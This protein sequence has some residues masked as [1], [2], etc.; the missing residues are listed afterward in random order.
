MKM[1]LIAT[2]CFMFVASIAT[3]SL[4]YFAYNAPEAEAAQQYEVALQG[5]CE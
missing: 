4:A 2:S 1:P 3:F 5:P